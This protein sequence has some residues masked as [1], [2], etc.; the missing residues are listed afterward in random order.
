MQTCYFGNFANAWSS[1][2]KI[3]VSICR[4]LSCWSE[5]KKSTSSLTSF[6]SITKESKL[7]ILNDSDMI[8][9][10]HL[11]WSYQSEENFDDYLQT[12]NQRHSS[13]FLWCTGK[14]LQIC[15]FEYI[16][17]TWLC[18]LKTISSTC[19]KLS[20]LSANKKSTLSPLFF[21]R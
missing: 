14:I 4:M 2:S 20:F 17:H 1:P 3:M 5:C 15:Y 13:R 12:K 6:W 10:T 21:W 19:R 16:G 8:L 9:S 7:V 11:N 18:T